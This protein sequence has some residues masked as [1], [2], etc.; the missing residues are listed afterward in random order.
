VRA[1]IAF[2]AGVLIVATSSHF[3]LAETETIGSVRTVKETAF[4]LRKGKTLSAKKGLKLV[5]G[6][7]LKTG[8]G[9]SIGV[10]L[11]DDTILTLGPG[12]EFV[13]DTFNFSPAEGKLS[14]VTRMIRGTVAYF[15]GQIGKLSPESV[16]FTTPV[17][18]IGIRGTRFVAKI[19][20]D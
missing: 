13:I 17:A 6:D 9:G 10:I 4:I 18:T 20:G 3:A 7:I 16:R 11:R 2:F 14:I 5:Q 1:L 19:K 12:S 8:S 15:S